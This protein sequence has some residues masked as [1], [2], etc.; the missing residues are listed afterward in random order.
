MY[1]EG[2]GTKKD[3]S[4]Y[5]NW[6]EQASKNGFYLA[7]NEL[8]VI[9]EFGLGIDKNIDTAIEYY[10]KA[11]NCGCV[12]ALKNLERILGEEEEEPAKPSTP[13]KTEEKEFNT[14]EKSQSSTAES[15]KSEMLEWHKQE[16]EKAEILKTVDIAK[17]LLREGVSVEIIANCTKLS[18]EKIKEIKETLN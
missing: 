18:L 15:I 7:N 3:L 13:P 12:V 9:Y 8:G 1:R 16:I 11:M 17:N 5:K 10:T 14:D 6:C 4:E 2:I